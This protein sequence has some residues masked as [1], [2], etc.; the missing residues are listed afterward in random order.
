M[1]MITQDNTPVIL[2]N[3]TA[4]SSDVLFLLDLLLKRLELPDGS[5]SS[6]IAFCDFQPLFQAKIRLVIKFINTFIPVEPSP[7][8]KARPWTI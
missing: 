5:I 3:T 4:P 8:D 2:V 6:M 1:T 7:L